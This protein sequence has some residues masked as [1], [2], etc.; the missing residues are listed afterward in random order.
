MFP[1]IFLNYIDYFQPFNV[2]RYITF[3]TGGAILTALLLSFLLGPYLIK[4]LKSIQI[5]GQPI[6]NDGP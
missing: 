4:I 1:E 3:R 6:R 5:E 2:F